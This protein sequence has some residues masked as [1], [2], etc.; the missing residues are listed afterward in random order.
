LGAATGKASDSVP[1]VDSDMVGKQGVFVVCACMS[2]GSSESES[3]Q[4]MTTVG[5][6]CSGQ[7]RE[8]GILF[9]TG[10]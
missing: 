2:S 3:L 6:G 8:L 4:T 1:F 10:H 7:A 5:K 9:W